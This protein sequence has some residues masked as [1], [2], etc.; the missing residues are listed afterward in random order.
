VGMKMTAASN[1]KAGASCSG[2]SAGSC[3][4]CH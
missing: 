2:C 4:T 1:P 3:S